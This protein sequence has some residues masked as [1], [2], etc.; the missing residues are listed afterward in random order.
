LMLGEFVGFAIIGTSGA[1]DIGNSKQI[2]WEN[3]S[4]GPGACSTKF[5]A[6]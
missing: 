4:C 3:R 5:K 2:D 1:G 6:N